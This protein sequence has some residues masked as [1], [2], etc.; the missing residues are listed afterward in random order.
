M[1]ERPHLLHGGVHSRVGTAA[2]VTLFRGGRLIFSFEKMGKTKRNS[3]ERTQTLSDVSA[4][5]L[6]Q[7]TLRQRPPKHTLTLMTSTCRF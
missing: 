7:R 6:F 5:T 4:F 3:N 2:A 1:H